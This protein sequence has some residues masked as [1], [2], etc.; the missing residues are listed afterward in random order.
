MAW[1]VFFFF[2]HIL[3]INQFSEGNS[4]TVRPCRDLYSGSLPFV[5]SSFLR[6]LFS[7]VSPTTSSIPLSFSSSLL[8]I[9]LFFLLHLLFLCFTLRKNK[10]HRLRPI[11]TE[12]TT[13]K[14]MQ[15][16]RIIVMDSSM[17]PVGIKFL[18]KWNLYLSSFRFA[19]NIESDVFSIS[20][21]L[22]DIDIFLNFQF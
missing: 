7:S 11:H 1:N 17:F 22:E 13:F 2:F 21:M 6:L 12:L 9:R 15:G 10:E 5:S 20:I 4:E 8:L 16:I 18:C 19:L 3:R 14:T